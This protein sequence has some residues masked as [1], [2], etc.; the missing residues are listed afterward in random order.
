MIRKMAEWPADVH[1]NIPGVY[2]AED[3]AILYDIRAAV[4]PVPPKG[5]WNVKKQKE[6]EAATTVTEY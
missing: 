4:K 6:A 5:G 1:W 3:E 2:F